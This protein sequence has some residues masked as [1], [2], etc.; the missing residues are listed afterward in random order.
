MDKLY[1]EVRWSE[2]L[3]QIN[4]TPE[5]AKELE[6]KCCAGEINAVSDSSDGIRA[7][8]L[9]VPVIVDETLHDAPYKLIYDEDQYCHHPNTLIQ[10][11]EI[12]DGLYTHTKQRV[13]CLN[14]GKI[15]FKEER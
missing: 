5:F 6:A 12:I 8:Y 7:E 1:N 13:K 11:A 2:A 3:V 15:L 14:C 10:T 9:G 4:V